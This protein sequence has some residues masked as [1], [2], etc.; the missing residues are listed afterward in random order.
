MIPVED[1]HYCPW[2]AQTLPVDHPCIG[3]S[4]IPC[5]ARSDGQVCG[6]CPA[7][8]SAQVADP[9]Y[10]RNDNEENS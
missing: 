10:A 8:I 4:R 1:L 5:V 9:R 2:E 7:C 3:D 6:I